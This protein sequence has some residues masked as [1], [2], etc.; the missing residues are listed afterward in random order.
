MTDAHTI[1]A[2]M[3]SEQRRCDYIRLGDYS[4]LGELLHPDLVHVHT[5]GNQDTRESYLKYVTEVIEI[6][7]VERHELSVKVY[8]DAAVMS[9]VQISTA[10]AR[11]AVT[12]GR[13]EELVVVKTQ[14][15]QVWVHTDRWQLVAFQA[16]ALGPLPPPPPAR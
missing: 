13:T 10:R 9:G 16:T 11:R 14:V 2:V 4:A 7:E 1:A 12:T 5:R 8:G 6:L 3:E 15:L